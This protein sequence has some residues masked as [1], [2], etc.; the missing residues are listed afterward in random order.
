MTAPN[1][2]SPIHNGNEK[3]LMRQIM[4]QLAMNRTVPPMH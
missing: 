3:A 2:I 1:D 4:S